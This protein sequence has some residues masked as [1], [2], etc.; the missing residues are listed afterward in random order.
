MTQDIRRQLE[1]PA[2]PALVNAPARYEQMNFAQNNKLLRTFFLKISNIFNSLLGPAGAQYI[3]F[4]HGL[5]FSVE[6]QSLLGANTATPVEF[7]QTYLSEFVEVNAGTESRINVSVDGVYNFQ[8]SG[9]LTS[10]NSSSKIVYVWIVRNG[11]NIGYSTH[12]YTISGSNTKLEIN[13]NFNIDLQA[14]D[15]LELEWASA[16]T[17][18]TLT[19]VLPAT[20]HPG[21]PSAVMAVSYVSPIPVNLPTPP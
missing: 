13:W 9:Q 19:A 3:S 14:G 6:T 5:F 1:N 10:T 12:A 4:P 2:P 11:I 17:N 8:F 7:E 18:V 21:I 16:D 15:Y 20:P